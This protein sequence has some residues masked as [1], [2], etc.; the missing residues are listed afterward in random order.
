VLGGL[1]EGEKEGAQS[2]KAAV[3]CRRIVMGYQVASKNVWLLLRGLRRG[4]AQTPPEF[5]AVAGRQRVARY[6]STVVVIAQMEFSGGEGKNETETK[7]P[8]LEP[9]E[10][11]VLH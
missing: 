2:R 11:R 6:P 7:N 1:T 5:G 10:K 4:G 3:S 8:E 9:K